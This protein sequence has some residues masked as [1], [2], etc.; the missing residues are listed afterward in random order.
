MIVTGHVHEY[1]VY[2]E[3]GIFATE[4]GDRTSVEMTILNLSARWL[5]PI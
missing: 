2:L 4:N 1:D 3:S 5:R